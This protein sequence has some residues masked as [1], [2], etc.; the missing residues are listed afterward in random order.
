MKHK[1]PLV[2]VSLLMAIVLYVYVDG[3]NYRDLTYKPIDIPIVLDNV[4][5][6]LALD[7]GPS[8]LTL[9]PQGP[10][11]D[12]Q[13]LYRLDSSGKRGATIHVNCQRAKAGEEGD[14]SY[15]IEIPDGLEVEFKNRP[16]GIRLTFDRMASRTVPVVVE[17]TGMPPSGFL[18]ST[19]EADPARIL[20]RGPSKK[21][22]QVAR[23]VVGVDL[24]TVRSGQTIEAPIFLQKENAVPADSTV[25]ADVE[26]VKVRFALSP[27]PEE[28]RLVISPVVIGQPA[29]GYRIV[30][31]EVSPNQAK[32]SGATNML[33]NLSTVET[34]PFDITGLKAT[35]EFRPGLKLPEGVNDATGK[36]VLVRVVVEPSEGH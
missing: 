5:T 12:L 1:I 22:E 4:P 10:S 17:S 3:Q 8:K 33:A 27:R 31:I 6:D 2:L 30:R 16:S 19:I 28:V 23:A 14:F 29:P 34:Q 35:A 11:L 15:T 25:S 20:V 13:Q 21:L 7:A 36:Q 9:F 18:V 26:T 32:L 24:S